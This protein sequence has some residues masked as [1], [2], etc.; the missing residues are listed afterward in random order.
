VAEPL[1]VSAFHMLYA[2]W[3][4]ALETTTFLGYPIVQCP[5][6][7]QI[8]QE[9]VYRLKPAYI[10]QTGVAGGGS[11]LYFAS[12]L[13]L[14]GAPPSATVVGIDIVLTE[15]ARSLSQHERIHLFEGSS[16]DSAVVEQ[17]R[18]ILPPGGG[19]VSLD[20][21]HSKEH[22]LAE[23]HIYK[24]FVSV[25]SYMVVEDTHVNGHPIKRTFGPGPYE[26][27]EEFLRVDSSFVRDDDLWKRNKFSFHQGGWLKRI[28]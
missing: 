16:V 21:D 20:S 23:M 19:M 12:L 8:Y 6:D 13:D 7:L 1:I 17:I 24:E 11:I 15:E 28:G 4:N 3:G 9:L 5:L 2:G 10:L 25:G 14:M 27:V 22:V 26:A 18:K